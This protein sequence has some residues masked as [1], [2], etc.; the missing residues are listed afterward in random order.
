MC[1]CTSIHVILHAPPA[2]CCNLSNKEAFAACHAIDIM[3]DD[4]SVLRRPNPL[5][6]I[7]VQVKAARASRKAEL[8]LDT[9]QQALV[10][11]QPADNVSAGKTF[12]IQAP[13][14]VKQLQRQKAAERGRAALRRAH[15]QRRAEE[16][17]RQLR[18]AERAK[19]LHMAQ[20][21]SAQG[22]F[23]AAFRMP[24]DQGN[25][26][27]EAAA[28]KHQQSSRATQLTAGG[29]AMARPGLSC[30][31]AE[32]ALTPQRAP[33]KVIG[34]TQWQLQAVQPESHDFLRNSRGRL[35]HS[36][37]AG[38][39]AMCEKAL[40]SKPYAQGMAS[41]RHASGSSE[42]LAAEARLGQDRTTRR[43]PALPRLKEA[44]TYTASRTRAIAKQLGRPAIATRRQE[45]T[46]KGHAERVHTLMWPAVAKLNT[47]RA[48]HCPALPLKGHKDR[49][50]VRAACSVSTDVSISAFA[51]H[52]S[53]EAPRPAARRQCFRP[54]A[55]DNPCKHRLFS[56]PLAESSLMLDT[57]NTEQHAKPAAM[58]ATA[59]EITALCPCSASE[60]LPWPA[61]T[62]EHQACAMPS[63]TSAEQKG[64]NIFACHVRRSDSDHFS[65]ILKVDHTLLTL[66]HF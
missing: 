13:S 50:A 57:E 53:V 55:R 9:R 38:T 46:L 19:H 54:T 29:T 4:V 60:D 34:Q 28:G 21:G 47:Q 35:Q 37:A 42:T 15:Q 2:C 62:L 32:Q 26:Q 30:Q 43:T 44:V 59:C 48:T 64:G 14:S 56:N 3:T 52:M 11:P 25:M 58:P 1:W 33:L 18:S 8:G 36:T 23:P 6:H 65:Y 17:S 22:T 7:H 61:V 45:A 5:R 20:H 12:G 51:D 66:V 27:R 49:S 63:A 41:V 39:A 10:S 40:S 16:L 24:Q 31:Q